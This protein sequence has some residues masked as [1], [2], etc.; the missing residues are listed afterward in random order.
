[1]DFTSTDDIAVV[2]FFQGIANL[3]NGDFTGSRFLAKFDETGTL[4]WRG[5]P[6]SSWY[7]LTGSPSGT[8]FVGATSTTADFGWGAPLAGTGGLVIAKY[9]N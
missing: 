6:P 9:G 4:V 7:A 8:V 5:T 2:G 3:G 1:M